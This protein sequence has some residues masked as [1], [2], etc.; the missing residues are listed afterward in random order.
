MHTMII[1]ILYI[2]WVYLTHP[3][4]QGHVPELKGRYDCQEGRKGIK[5]AH[6]GSFFGR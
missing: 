3:G 6:F 5:K 1:Q 4:S 2:S